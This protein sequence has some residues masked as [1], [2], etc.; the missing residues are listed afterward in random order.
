M[1]VLDDL[2]A[3]ARELSGGNV[4]VVVPTT[5]ITNQRGGPASFASASLDYQVPGGL[6]ANRA[7]LSG[8]TNYLF[9]DRRSELKND[10]PPA[11]Q[12][13][14]SPPTNRFGETEADQID[15]GIRPPR[16]EINRFTGWTLR[17]TLLSWGNSSVSVPLEDLEPGVVGGVGAGIGGVPQ[18]RYVVSFGEPARIVPPH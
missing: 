14:W 7:S 8:R 6:L 18:A 11:G 13:F 15:I 17:L 1:S 2:F 12:V 16:T 10:G 9:S 5:M 3:R 4:R